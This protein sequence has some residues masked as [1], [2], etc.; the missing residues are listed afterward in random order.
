MI[1]CHLWY[2]AYETRE[3][4]PVKWNTQARIIHLPE[5]RV[6]GVRYFSAKACS[7]IRLYVL[8]VWCIYEHMYHL[9]SA[10]KRDCVCNFC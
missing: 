2:R 6:F 8:F 10:L 4:E 1:V 5:V 3:F 9:S 7:S